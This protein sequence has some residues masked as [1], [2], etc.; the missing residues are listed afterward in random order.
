MH[1]DID[2]LNSC[3]VDKSPEDLLTFF[4]KKYKGRIGLASSLGLE[5]QV[6]TDMILKID[7][8]TTIFSIDTGRLFPETY[9]L[10]DNINS[11]Y[12]I[13]L[14]IYM[15]KSEDVEAYIKKN[16]VNGF[17]ES[18]DKRKEC[19]RIRKIEPLLRALS[20]L[21][22]WICGLRREQSVTRSNIRMVEWDEVNKLIKVNPLV[23][24]KE[25]EIW[26]YIEIN[27]VPYNVLQKR[28]FPSVGCQPCTR[29]IKKGEDIRA[30]RW[31]WESSEHKECGLHKR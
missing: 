17:Y 22:V 30:G 9:L 21:D 26:S 5:D 24:W 7:S 6:L 1:E 14:D 29:A 20:A 15:P 18:L 23:N 10:I 2:L 25:Q 4:L 28:G 13:K 12:N 19:C 8:E 3:F 31:W 11:V 27:Q 16:G